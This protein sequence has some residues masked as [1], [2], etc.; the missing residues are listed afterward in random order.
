MQSGNIHR[1][2]ESHP[3]VSVII[4]CY[5]SVSRLPKTLEHLAKQVVPKDFNWEIIVVNNASTDDTAAFAQDIWDN[6]YTEFIR[7]RI[8]D[9]EQQG[10]FYARKRG[11]QEAAFDYVIFCDDDNWLDPDYV[12]LA[13][14]VLN[15][16]AKIG[17]AG[18]QNEPVTDA[19][20]YPDW[21][22]TYK[23]KYAIG[24]P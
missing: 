3:G 7:F 5:N 8:V 21:F 14:D 9:E 16:D 23:D 12:S 24:I 15:K 22:E 4:C 1:E 20:I 6:L 19:G 18:G 13:F 17:A 10:Q 11:A 2:Q